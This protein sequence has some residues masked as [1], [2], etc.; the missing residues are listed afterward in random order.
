M[1]MP[2]FYG[3][4]EFEGLIFLTVLLGVFVQ[5][6]NVS[7]YKGYTMNDIALHNSDG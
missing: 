5:Y 7:T 4:N 3:P 2:K 1:F 6:C